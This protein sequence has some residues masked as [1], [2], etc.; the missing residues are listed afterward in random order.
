[1][2]S[3]R[4]TGALRLVRWRSPAGLPPSLL[5]KR[6]C[7]LILA[8]SAAADPCADGTLLYSMDPGTTGG[9]GGYSSTDTAGLPADELEALLK[10]NFD[11]RCARWG[12]AGQNSTIDRCR[13]QA[14]GPCSKAGRV[15]AE[16]AAPCAP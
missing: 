6:P 10:Q 11:Y 1:M 13:V 7:P 2:R 3:P 15:G 9:D 5:P 4:A 12:V 16:P 14:P 8:S